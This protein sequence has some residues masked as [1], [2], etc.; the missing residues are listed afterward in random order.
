MHLQDALGRW[1][2]RFP[3]VLTRAEVVHGGAA[4]ALLEASNSAALVVLGR[5]APGLPMAAPRLGPVTHV[6]LHRAHVPVA[7]VPHD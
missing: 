5:R 1:R 3:D 4:E 6:V 7:V 2:E